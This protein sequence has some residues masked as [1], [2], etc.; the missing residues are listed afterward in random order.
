[1]FLPDQFLC[2]RLGLFLRSKGSG[3]GFD[4]TEH[5]YYYKGRALTPVTNLCSRFFPKFD[6]I[7]VS[8][9][10]ACKELGFAE[11]PTG[12]AHFDM[13]AHAKSIRASWKE[14]SAVGSL[15]HLFA[16][17]NLAC[18]GIGKDVACGGNEL[19]KV[20]DSLYRLSPDYSPA[21]ADGVLEYLPGLS[22]FFTDH[23]DD[24]VSR[25]VCTEQV[26]WSAEFSVAGQV[27]FITYNDDGSVELWDWKTS[28]SIADEGLNFGKFGYGQLSHLPDTN[29]YHYCLQLSIYRRLLEDWGLTVRGLHLIH[30]LPSSVEQGVACGGIENSV[31][32]SVP[33]ELYRIIDLPYLQDE[34][35]VVLYSNQE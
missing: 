6:S 22:A 31:A 26:V 30:V 5:R 15:F 25:V 1:M 14:K 4:G 24:I 19:A 20:D 3:V 9:S 21:A 35:G 34:A 16:Q 33:P 23:R 11:P 2:A 8:E 27:D 18:G 13:L 10:L 12:P 7:G 28:K 32:D 17:Y 29:F